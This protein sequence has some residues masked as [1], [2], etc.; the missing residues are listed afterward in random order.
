MP[1]EDP[2]PP[3]PLTAASARAIATI[4][5]ISRSRRKIDN[6]QRSVGGARRPNECKV[7]KRRVSRVKMLSPK[8]ITMNTKAVFMAFDFFALMA[9]LFAIR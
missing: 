4:T 5:S 2:K 8:A 1:P 7:Q 3:A 9:K 6:L